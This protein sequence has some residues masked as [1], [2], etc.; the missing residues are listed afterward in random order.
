MP[1][2]ERAGAG[3]LAVQALTEADQPLLDR[4]GVDAAARRLVG[5][6]LA[7]AGPGPIEEYLKLF[8]A[9][10]AAGLNLFALT[11]DSAAGAD[12]AATGAALDARM[13]AAVAALSRRGG[14][15]LVLVDAARA[16]RT[17]QPAILLNDGVA[18]RTYA[19]A[20]LDT[21]A[22]RKAAGNLRTA[23]L[24]GGDWLLPGGPDF[25]GLI[26]QPGILSETTPR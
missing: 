19:F 20:S 3:A 14:R 2:F 24:D 1:D 25:D 17:D 9:A 6:R 7:K 26:S 15:V 23:G 22:A 11:P 18:S 8:D 10:Q 5:E 21:P 4:Y 16:R 13:A 12:A